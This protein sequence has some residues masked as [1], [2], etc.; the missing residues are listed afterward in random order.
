MLHCRLVKLCILLSPAKICLVTVFRARFMVEDSSV[1]F[2]LIIKPCAF[3]PRFDKS[4]RNFH[5]GVQHIHNIYVMMKP[6]FKAS[7][8]PIM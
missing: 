5:L 4:S 7:D 3:G 8:G 1:Q 2:L 6:S